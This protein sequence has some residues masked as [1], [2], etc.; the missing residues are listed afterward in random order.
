MCKVSIEEMQAINGG[1]K[2]ICNRCG[3]TI[4][5]LGLFT[6]CLRANKMNLHQLQ[7]HG[8]AGDYS[9]KW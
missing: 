9:I 3:Y 2:I 5:A 4:T 7:R 1:M 8:C 6:G